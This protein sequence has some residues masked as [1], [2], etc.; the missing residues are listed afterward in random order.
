MNDKVT[1]ESGSWVGKTIQ[2]FSESREELRKVH[3]PTRQ[4]TIRMTWVVLLIIVFISVCLFV[5]DRTFFWLM[6]QLIG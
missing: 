3:S 4:E 5:V 6:S 2:Y 1:A